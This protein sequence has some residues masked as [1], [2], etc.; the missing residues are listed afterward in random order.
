MNAIYTVMQTPNH[1]LSV[2]GCLFYLS[3][4]ICKHMQTE[5]RN[6]N[7]VAFAILMRHTRIS[8]QASVPNPSDFGLF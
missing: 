5:V 2:K 8:I 7:D 6:E 3:Q 4:G 1:G